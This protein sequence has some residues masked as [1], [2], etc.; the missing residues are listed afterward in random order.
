MLGVKLSAN[1]DGTA[2]LSIFN[3]GIPFDADARSDG[4]GIRLIRGLAATLDR[5]YVLDGSKG[6]DFRITFATMD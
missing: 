3:D 4:T 5:A 1:G 6:L 2:R